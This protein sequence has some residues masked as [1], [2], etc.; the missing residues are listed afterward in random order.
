MAAHD[1]RQRASIEP[2]EVTGADIAA[3]RES[4]A[5][6]PAQRIAE[7]V[8]MNRLHADIQSR[9]IDEKQRRAM[10]ALD[11]EIARARLLAVASCGTEG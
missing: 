11:V 3:L 8:E 4:L 9:T 2:M 7:L 10:E 6:S 1:A 5:L